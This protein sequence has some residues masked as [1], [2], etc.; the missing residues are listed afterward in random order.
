MGNMMIVYCAYAAAMTGPADCCK[1]FPFPHTVLPCL[2]LHDTFP[3]GLDANLPRTVPHLQV[4]ITAAERTRPGLAVRR[5][6]MLP[7]P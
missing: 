7:S 2:H 4:P 3:A 6:N 1:R 5:V